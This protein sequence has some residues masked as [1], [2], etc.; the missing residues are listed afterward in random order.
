MRLACAQPLSQPSRTA[1]ITNVSLSTNP[2]AALNKRRPMGESTDDARRCLHPFHSDALLQG[3][4]VR[5]HHKDI[6]KRMRA[7]RRST[8]ST[9]RMK[10]VDKFKDYAQILSYPMPPIETDDQEPEA[11]RGIRQDHQRRLRRDLRAS[12]PTISPAGSAQAPL[13]APDAGVRE[14]A[15]RHARLARS[16]CRS[17]P[18]SPASRSTIRNSS[19]S[20]RR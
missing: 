1:A 20:G 10:V 17:T 11:D 19:R 14:A 9:S 13:A 2:I 18:T 3:G 16:A 5:R 4:D 12:I 6:G 8:T 15:A 7:C